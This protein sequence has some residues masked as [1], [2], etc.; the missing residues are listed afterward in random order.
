M[1]YQSL[2]TNIITSVVPF[3]NIQPNLWN[4]YM[5]THMSIFIRYVILKSSHLNLYSLLY[6]TDGFKAALNK[7]IMINEAN[8][9]VVI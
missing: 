7:K 1:L 2:V 8:N 5:S 3:L 9:C 6:N 4:L